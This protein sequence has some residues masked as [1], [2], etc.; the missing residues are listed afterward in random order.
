MHESM[1]SSHS[2]TNNRNNINKVEILLTEVE[3]QK[4]WSRDSSHLPEVVRETEEMRLT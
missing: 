1:G 2:T 3:D 4:P